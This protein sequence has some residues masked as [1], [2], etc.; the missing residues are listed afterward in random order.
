MR[1]IIKKKYQRILAQ[2]ELFNLVDD[3]S[4]RFIHILNH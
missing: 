4:D 1:S 3:L 2:P